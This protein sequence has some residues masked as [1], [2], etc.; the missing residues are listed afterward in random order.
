MKRILILAVAMLLIAGVA[1]AAGISGSAHDMRQLYTTAPTGGYAEICIYC[2]TPHSAATSGTG[3]IPLWNRSLQTGASYTVYTSSTFNN[4]MPGTLNL[5]SGA[6]M[7]CHDGTVAIS[8]LFNTPNA[9]GTIGSGGTKTTADKLV[10]G[11][12]NEYFGTDLSDDHP[13]SINMSTSITNETAAGANGLNTV[14]SVNSGG[15]ARL[16]G[17]GTPSYVECASCHN[18]HNT[19]FTPFLRS[20]NAGSLLCLACH[21]K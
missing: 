18:V 3:T 21:N 17:T 19:A 6:C 10:V 5:G 16:F 15:K 7:T 1:Y 20:T 9:G 12:G 2:H 14:A 11:A 8:A 13:V 4:T